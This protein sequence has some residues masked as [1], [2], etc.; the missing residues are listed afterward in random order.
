M[1]CP[2]VWNFFPPASSFKFKR[3]SLNEIKTQC[4]DLIDFHYFNHLVCNSDFVL[5]VNVLFVK[6]NVSFTEPVF[7]LQVSVI[8]P[9]TI[10]VSEVITDSLNEDCDY[11][12]VEDIHV[13]HL[14]SKEF[15][16]AFVKKGTA[17]LVFLL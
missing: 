14:I 5:Y 4:T 9:D 1:L 2:E 8:L 6:I 10:N 12:E 13:S 11:Y 17:Q 15:I 3:G 7:C 16:E